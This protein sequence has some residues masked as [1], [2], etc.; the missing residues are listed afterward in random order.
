[1]LVHV[2]NIWVEK[3][4]FSGNQYTTLFVV[5]IVENQIYLA[6]AGPIKEA[7]LILT[8]EAVG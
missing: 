8:V 7:V 1:M 2:Q 4:Q 5:I 3:V 6:M